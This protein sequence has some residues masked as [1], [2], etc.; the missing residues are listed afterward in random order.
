MQQLA[1]F[2]LRHRRWVIGFWAVVF[3]AG[4][5][6]ASTTTSR[7]TIDFSLPGQ[8]GTET[9]HSIEK[10][11]GNG[12]DTN[13][14]VVTVTLPAGSTITGNEAA[15]A[16]VFAAVASGVPDVRVV[17]EANTGDKAF[18][19]TD[20]RTAYALVFY[21]F[22]PSPTAKLHHRTGAR[23]GHP[24]RAARGSHRR[25]RRGRARGRR[26][27]QR[28]WRARRDDDRCPGR[29]DRA[30]VRVRLVPG[31][32]APRRRRGLDPGDVPDAAPHH[33]RHRRLLHRAS[34]SSR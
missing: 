32:P 1:E 4:A 21:R 11:F 2:V 8:P 14:F 28:T 27:Q 3:L 15:V 6:L 31:V 29:P 12:G 22:N 34:S 9:A 19:T 7:L 5:G 25:D 20:D 13:P 30:G 18:R 24:G 17:D 23:G 33:L 10:A 16:K 26:Q